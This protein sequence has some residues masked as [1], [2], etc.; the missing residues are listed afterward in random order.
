L[1]VP[2]ELLDGRYL[3]GREIGQGAHGQVFAATDTSEQRAVAIKVLNATL[4]GDD[5]FVA[6][7]WREARALQALWNQSVVEVYGFGQDEDGSVYMVMEHLQGQT[8]AERLEDLELFNSRMSAYDVLVAVEPIARA[9][10]IAHRMGIIHRDVKPSNIFLLDEGSSR[11]MDFG[12][13]KV[14]DR[15]ALTRAGVVA[16]SPHYMAPEMLRG[17]GFDHRIDVYSLAAVIFRALAGQPMFPGD[18]AA[19]VLLRVLR[20]PRP[21]LHALR[22]DLPRQIDAWVQEALCPDPSLR[23]LD[24]TS[25]WNGLLH[26]VQRARTPSARKARSLE[27]I[28]GL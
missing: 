2:G 8:L 22:P 26:V 25:M 13:A 16:G 27:P 20:E 6:R 4:E 10:H 12:L 15:L 23:Y 24:A 17:E 7:L 11:L 9:L 18:Q 21:S 5:Q 28:E 19:E 14:D 1:K 3:L